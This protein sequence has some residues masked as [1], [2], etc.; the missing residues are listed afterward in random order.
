MD[1]NHSIALLIVG[2][3]VFILVLLLYVA[4]VRWVFRINDIISNLEKLN[5]KLAER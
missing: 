2:L 5:E 3:G 4:L 1:T